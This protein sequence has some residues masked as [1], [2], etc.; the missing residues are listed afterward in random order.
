MI[1]FAIY[2]SGNINILEI[3]CLQS[4]QFSSVY[5]SSDVAP[6]YEKNWNILKIVTSQSV[7]YQIS[8]KH[9]KSDQMQAYF[10]TILSKY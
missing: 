9:M 5:K 7:Y 6:T 3:Y 10:E 1:C 8:S 2:F 4:Y